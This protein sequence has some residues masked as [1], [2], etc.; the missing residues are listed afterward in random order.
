MLLSQVLNRCKFLLPMRGYIFADL[1][2][3]NKVLTIL[4]TLDLE[5]VAFGPLVDVLDIVCM[6]R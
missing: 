4:E 5:L 1:L 6:S 3:G 2:L